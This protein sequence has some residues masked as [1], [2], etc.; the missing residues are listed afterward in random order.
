VQVE[1]VLPLAYYHF[2][3]DGKC[4][5][6]LVI[7]CWAKAIDFIVKETSPFVNRF[8]LNVPL[9]DIRINQNLFLFLIL[10]IEK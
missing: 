1:S 7:L 5:R 8:L 9:D 2:D 4:L 3:G 10:T 6:P